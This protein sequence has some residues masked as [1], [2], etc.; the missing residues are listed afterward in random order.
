ML[1]FLNIRL[2]SKGIISHLFI[3]P[4]AYHLMCSTEL[5][6]ISNVLPIKSQLL[7]STSYIGP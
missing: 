3:E 2:S 1:I 7:Q 6:D 5:M 4:F